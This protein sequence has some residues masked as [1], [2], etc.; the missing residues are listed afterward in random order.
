[1]SWRIATSTRVTSAYA[2]DV[3]VRQTK[4]RARGVFSMR[5]FYRRAG[6]LSSRASSAAGVSTGIPVSTVLAGASLAGN[7]SSSVSSSWLSSS[8]TRSSG[9]ILNSLGAAD[10]QSREE[11]EHASDDH[12][13]RRREKRRVH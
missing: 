8:D 1:M 2:V 10:E 5:G 7:V 13:E 4:T 3:S 6:V 12:L 9:S 11:H